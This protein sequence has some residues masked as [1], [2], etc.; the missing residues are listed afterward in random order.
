M[1]RFLD[2][3]AQAVGG[4]VAGFVGTAEAASIADYSSVDPTAWL[5]GIQG[6]HVWIATHGFNVDRKSGIDGLSKWEGLLRLDPQSAFVGL[7]WPGDSVWAHGLDYPDEPRVANA[8]GLLLASFL[9]EHFG[10]AASISFVSHSLG[11]R[12]VLETVAAM[13]LPMRR[14]LLMAAA[15]DDD[16]LQKEFKPAADNIGELSTLSSNEDHVLS[17][18]S[19]GQFPRGYRD[20]GPPVVART[21]GPIGAFQPPAPQ[22]QVA[23]SN[24]R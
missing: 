10:G 15:I 3:R 20:Q 7:L 6:R 19:A 16:C 2:V 17:F 9:D 1:T 18:L 4:S 21:A 11:A 12:V 8:A 14:A 13:S 24:S 5:A 22:L 23:V